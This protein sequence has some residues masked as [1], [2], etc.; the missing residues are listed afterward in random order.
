VS[1]GSGDGH[2]SWAPISCVSQVQSRIAPPASEWAVPAKRAG[3]WSRYEALWS[4]DASYTDLSECLASP[5]PASEPGVAGSSSA[6][7]DEAI[8]RRLRCD[9]PTG[10]RPSW[11]GTRL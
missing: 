3:G 1:T 8:N 7:P 6:Q 11:S 5:S 10:V 2:H 4:S 9:R